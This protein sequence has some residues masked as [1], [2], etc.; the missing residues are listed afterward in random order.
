[1]SLTYATSTEVAVEVAEGM[2]AGK[3]VL[4]S[5]CPEAT[6]WSTESYSVYVCVCV[7]VCDH[8]WICAWRVCVRV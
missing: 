8:T 5:G 3:T 7:C 6:D 4:E 2:A 1:M